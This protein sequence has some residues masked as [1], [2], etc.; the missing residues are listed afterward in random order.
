MLGHRLWCVVKG[1]M[2]HPVNVVTMGP[3][4]DDGREATG[5][6]ALIFSRKGE[7][8]KGDYKKN[9]MDLIGEEG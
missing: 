4:T 1:C 6:K 9:T 7:E 8:R 2:V 3:G 5:G